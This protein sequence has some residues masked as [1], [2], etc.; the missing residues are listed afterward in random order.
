MAIR[1]GIVDCSIS[2][3]ASVLHAF[4]HIGAETT[5]TRDPDELNTFTHLV[6]PGVGS[7]AK[8]MENLR[9]TGFVVPLHDW[10]SAGK[11]LLGLC[12]GMQLLAEE[13]EEFGPNGGL[14]LIR[15]RVVKMKPAD[16][17]LRLP[18]VG[19]NE[20]AQSGASRLLVGLGDS[21]TFYFVHSYC[22]GE[23]G[24]DYVTGTCEYGGPQVALVEHGNVFGAQ[25]HPEKSQKAGLTLLANFI[26]IAAGA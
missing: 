7:F 20:V 19:W 15:G 16:P 25:F 23:P 14:G 8:G 18:H 11:P 9:A 22:Y 26:S 10:A 5:V 13:G 17:A 12:L 3:L 6:L 2:N 21:P 4:R 24:A 1:V